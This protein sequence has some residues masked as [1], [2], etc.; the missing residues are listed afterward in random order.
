MM[1]KID[2]I[3]LKNRIVEICSPFELPGISPRVKKMNIKKK[4]GNEYW[5]NLVIENYSLLE[6]V[7]VKVDSLQNVNS[8]KICDCNKL[9]TIEIEEG[10][11]RFVNKVIV[12]SS[13]K[14][15]S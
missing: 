3:N 13:I 9:H 11:C 2:S 7:Y 5:G 10:A 14:R 1:F 12:E 4:F 6:R 15:I 8:L